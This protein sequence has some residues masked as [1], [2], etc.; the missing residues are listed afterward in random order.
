MLVLGEGDRVIRRR[1]RAA[2][3]A[4]SNERRIATQPPVNIT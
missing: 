2:R 1:R 3:E 4:A